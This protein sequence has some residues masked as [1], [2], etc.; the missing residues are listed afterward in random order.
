MSDD[1]NDRKLILTLIGLLLLAAGIVIG[2]FG[3]LEMYCFTLFSE[4]GRFYYEGFGFGSF[5]FGNIAAQIIGYY[6]IGAVGVTLGYGH[7]TMRRWARKLTL[8]LLWFW[9][10]FGVPLTIV[11]L[12][13]LFA[14]KELSI[15]SGLVALVLAGLAYLVA[16]WLLMRFYRSR[17]VRLT[18]ETRDAK[19]SWIDNLP[20]PV[21][22]L[23]ALLLFFVV[24]L[25]IP[26]FFSGLF[27]FFGLLLVDLEGIFVLD[28]SIVC[29]TGLAW[30]L[31]KLKPWAWWGALVFTS[32]LTVSVIVTFVQY[33]LTDILSRMRFPP[34]EMEA[35]QNLPFHGFHLALMVGVP[36]LI[37]LGLLV[38]S[39]P[40]F[41]R[42]L[43]NPSD[44][45]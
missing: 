8:T 27:P 28:V 35:L 31:L 2:F 33:S 22:V 4:G 12:F 37:A 18:F 32:L 38:F 30:G 5:M 34:T 43:P 7:V 10:I 40:H 23:G 39:K 20:Q 24:V 15:V 45:A 9:V 44:Q 11:F 1:F 14:S 25:H 19:L 26:I 6:L 13:V 36:L 16:P 17:D 21:L 42:P 41:S 29:L 3:P